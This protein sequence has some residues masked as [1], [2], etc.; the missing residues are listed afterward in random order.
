MADANVAMARSETKPDWAWEASYGRRD[1]SF[2]DLASVGVRIGLPLF[3]GG[4]QKP[5]VEARRFDAARVASEQEAAL[6]EHTALLE[7]R[8]AEYA[9]LSANLTRARD[10]RLPLARQRAAAAIGAH[11]A[12][13]GSVTQLIDA[14]TAVL[15]AEID[16][17]DLEERLALIGAALSLEYGETP[18]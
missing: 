5:I 16:L 10:V 4:R 13:S 18:P 3:Q 15:E 8:L 1:P 2:G 7:Q 6:R 9:A 14:R 11:G 12:G 17:V